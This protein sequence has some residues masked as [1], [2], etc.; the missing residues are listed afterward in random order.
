MVIAPK[1]IVMYKLHSLFSKVRTKS[2]RLFSSS[3]SP[4][5]ATFP[6]GE[7]LFIISF[8]IPEYRQIIY[9][10]KPKN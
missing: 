8:N 1:T 3:V 6:A 7:G 2:L 4:R 5:A 9:P 10:Y